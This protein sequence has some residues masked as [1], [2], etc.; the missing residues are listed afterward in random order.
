MWLPR[1]K[2][3]NSSPNPLYLA[4]KQLCLIE[5]WTEGKET[6]ETQDTRDIAEHK[7][8]VGG[9]AGPLE[10]RG[11]GRFPL[12]MQP[13]NTVSIKTCWLPVAEGER[14]KRRRGHSKVPAEGGLEKKT[15]QPCSIFSEPRARRARGGWGVVSVGRGALY[16]LGGCLERAQRSSSTRTQRN[17]H[18]EMKCLIGGDKGGRGGS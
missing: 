13:H 3:S 14:D 15:R 10:E 12:V 9:G 11:A 16:Y 5:R 2:S 4:K 7:G 17:K 18:S 8:T 1:L 6:R